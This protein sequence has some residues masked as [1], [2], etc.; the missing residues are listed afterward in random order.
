M[1]Y[2]EAIQYLYSQFPCFQ[3]V[4]KSAFV[5]SLQ[6]TKDLLFFLGNPES[7]IPC[8]HVAGTNG[9]GST[10]HFIASILQESG[11]KVGLFTS[12]H[13]VDFTE[14]IRVNGDAISKKYVCAFVEKYRSKLEGMQASLF[15][16]TTALAFDYFQYKKV[17][18]AVIEVGLGGRLD[19][20][21]VINPLVS[22]ITN[23]GFDHMQILG[24]TLDKIALEKA[25]IIKPKVPVV[26]GEYNENTA[27]V[28][29]RVAGE[30]DSQI[31][32]ASNDYNINIENTSEFWNGE[33]EVKAGDSVKIRAKAGLVGEYQKKNVVTVYAAVEV[34]KECGCKITKDAI[35][36]GYK[37]VVENT[38][39]LG[40]WQK[41]NENPLTICD[42]GH[43]Y[44]GISYTM[45]QLVGLG[46]KDIRIVWGMVGDKDI[47]SIIDLLPETATYYICKP[48]IE[49]AMPIS[50]LEKY[51]LKKKYFIC[52]TVHDAYCA[53]KQNVTNETVIYV[54]GS[55]YVVAEFLS[56]KI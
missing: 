8:V 4:G 31:I 46:K 39:L 11:Y 48:N 16:V 32:F 52:E 38:H 47:D 7:K 3:Q 54:G 49:R 40:R 56:K 50:R 9:K 41:V 55:S 51:F 10:S 20:T 35:S 37:N 45:P 25:G 28:F 29:E 53:A 21:N 33:F 1:K 24:N 17:D 26:I 44:D 13:L 27:A 2:S 6:N 30:N 18:Y 15:E 19:S 12:P 34:L 14:R 42:T 43:N 5:P 22:V 23:I 36:K